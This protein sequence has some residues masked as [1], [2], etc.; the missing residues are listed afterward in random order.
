MDITLTISDTNTKL[1]LNDLLD[2][3]EWC[4]GM[5]D[6]KINNCQKRFL[7]EWQPKLFKDPLVTNIPANINDFVTL[8]VARDDYKNRAQR[9]AE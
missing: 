2:I 5:L 9:E 7:E 8:V 1:L 6:G 3:Q 4:Q